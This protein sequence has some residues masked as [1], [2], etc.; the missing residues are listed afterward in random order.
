MSA[1]KIHDKFSPLFNQ[2]KGV[3]YYIVTGGR[4]SSKS[5]S[6]SLWD[7]LKTFEKGSKTLYT[8]YTLI[9][10]KKSIIPEFEEKIEILNAQDHFVVNNNDITN[11]KTGSSILFSGIKTSSGNQTANLKS[12]QGISVWILDEAEELVDENTFDKIDLSIRSKD[13]QNIVVLILNPTTKEHWIYNKFFQDRGIEGGFNGVKDDTCYIHTTYLDNLDNL[14]ESYLNSINRI[15]TNNIDKYNHVIL[16]GWRNKA[17]GVIFEYEIGEFDISLPYYFG[18][19]FGFVTD[20]DACLKVAIDESK[21]IIYMDEQFY[22]NGQQLNEI[23]NQ[24]NK[25]AAGQI[26]ADSAEQRLISDIET[27]C[28]RTI[29]RVKKGA[30][31]VMSGIKLMKNYKIVI[32]ESSTNLAK[33][34]NN[35]TWNGKAKEA[36]IDMYNHLIDAARYVINTFANNKTPEQHERTDTGAKFNKGIA[37]GN[38][39]APWNIEQSNKGGQGIF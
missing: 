6:I 36:P 31:S 15:K 4:G 25:L 23:S 20:P 14:S 9:S 22:L 38:D 24:I 34:F 16:G 39:A 12:L 33:E 28:Q 18:L 35:Y 7:C 13:S 11:T 10:A 5:F 32:T 8:R 30:G 27:R 2:P 17:E 19:D 3:R 29:I 21:G 37:T 1:I 26:V